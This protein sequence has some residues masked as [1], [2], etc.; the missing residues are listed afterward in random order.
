MKAITIS[1]LRSK[2]KHYFD[3][4]INSSEILI[5]PRNNDDEA[6]VI[7]SLKEYNALQET[8]YLLSTDKNRERLLESIKQAESGMVKEVNLDAIAKS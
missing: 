2:I 8:N 6:I 3:S 5:I 4:V 7:M 1:N